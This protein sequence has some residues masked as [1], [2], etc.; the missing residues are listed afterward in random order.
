MRG[1]PALIHRMTGLLHPAWALRLGPGHG[2]PRRT[3]GEVGV[4]LAEE[5]R[6]GKIAGDAPVEEAVRCGYDEA[7]IEGALLAGRCALSSFR[8]AILERPR[9][10]PGAQVVGCD[11]DGASIE[12]GELSALS[13]CGSSLREA[14]IRRTHVGALHL[15]DLYGA[16]LERV[17][18]DCAQSTDF[19]AALLVDCD[20]S[21]ADLR[22]SC[23][24]RTELRDCTLA[25]ALV[26]GADFAG[27]R[28]LD[29]AVRRDL[30]AR[31]A[32]FHGAALT[33]SLR[34]L[35]PTADPLRLNRLAAVA[36]WGSLALGL[37][38][39][40]GGLG[41]ALTPPAPVAAPALPTP[42]DRPAT[43]EERDRTRQSLQQI[44]ENLARANE[45]MVR[46]GARNRAWP[47][48][49][50]FQENRYDID[51]DGPGEEHDALF[52]GGLPANFLTEVES[53]VLPYCNDVPDQNT[54][55]GVNTD[56]HYCESTGR[57]FA[58]AGFS[59]EATLNW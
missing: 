45:T 50:E 42:R 54:L 41:L 28:G 43:T 37:L 1:V 22:G 15:C 12:G 9:A 59:S 44:R 7:T 31:G 52:P 46:E 38:V 2:A 23:F 20:L 30:I 53:S 6:A 19:T 51:G 55:S 39:G 21:E 36:R 5:R 35:L 16:R 32:M 27:A 11:L 34:R 57:V 3:R 10:A 18:I 48:I 14:G 49:V 29:P 13:V 40:I 47:T 25:G 26:D 33:A 8:F 24:R 58:S 17:R 4:R 56:W